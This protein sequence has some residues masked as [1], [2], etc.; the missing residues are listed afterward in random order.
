MRCS[1]GVQVLLGGALI[2]DL[3]A[4]RDKRNAPDAEH[5][6]TDQFGRQ[7]FQYLCD[8]RMNDSVWSL[9]IWAYSQEDAEARIE[10]IRGSLAYLGQLYTVVS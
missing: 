3:N 9:R 5:I 6:R 8:Y 10:A 4:E 7:M 2:I 1:P